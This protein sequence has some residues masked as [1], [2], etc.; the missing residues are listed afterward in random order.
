MKILDIFE[1]KNKTETIWFGECLQFDGGWKQCVNGVKN[2]NCIMLNYKSD[3][4]DYFLY[5]SENGEHTIFRN[6]KY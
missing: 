3:Q 4:Y 5:Q 6:K 2:K 1:D